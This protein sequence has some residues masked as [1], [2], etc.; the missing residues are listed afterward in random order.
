MDEASSFIEKINKSYQPKE[1]YIYLGSGILNGEIIAPAQVNLSLKMMNRHGLVAGATGTGKTRTL[2]LIAEQLSD[3]G[4]PV[5]MLDVKGDLSGLHQAGELLPPL[6]ERGELLHR[7]FVPEGFPVELFSLSGKVGNPMRITIDEFGPVMLARVLDLN[8]T[9]TGVLTAI[10]KYADDNNMPLVDLEDLKKLL[11]YLS[12]GPGA[13]EIKTDYGSISTSSSSTILRKIVGLEQQGLA[14]IFG[15]TSF[16]IQDLFNREDGKGVISLL[17]IS[18]VQ[19]Q[20]LLFSTFL[21]SL[22]A[23]LF[24]KLPEVGNPEKPKLIFFFDEAHL[25]FK[26]A[27]KTFLSQIDQVIRLIRS[28]GVGV[29]FCTQAATDIP[30]NIL[31]QLGSRIQHALRAFTPNDADALKKTVKTYPHSEFY[32]ID[33]ILTQLGTGQALITVLNDKGIPTEVVATHLIPPRAKMDPLDPQSFQQL[34]VNS[35]FYMKYHTSL[36]PHSADEIID[37]KIAQAE[38]KKAQ[39][40]PTIK[41]APARKST[42]QTPMEAARKAVTSTVA[43]EIARGA[44]KVLVSMFSAL[45]GGKKKR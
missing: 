24:K 4:V 2:Q 45:L 7:P 34:V 11:N 22:L 8:D 5:F 17:N 30:E 10:F 16:D 43:R 44:S 6:V 14:N 29:F 9:Q 40:K 41:P 23:Q 15:E 21:M 12:Q 19:D 3:A 36:N 13:M 35:P 38:V 1:D 26:N 27:S 37:I 39:E 42:R 33:R 20:P 28:K 31:G 18:D 25:L 32:E